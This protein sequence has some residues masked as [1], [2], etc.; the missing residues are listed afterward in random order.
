MSNDAKVLEIKTND[1]ETIA[2]PVYVPT[3]EETFK[4]SGAH[5]QAVSAA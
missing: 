3:I 4:A 1:V 2:L 5:R